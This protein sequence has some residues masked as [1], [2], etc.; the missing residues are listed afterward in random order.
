VNVSLPFATGTAPLP[1]GFS[2]DPG[3]G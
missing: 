1:V 3:N 2:S